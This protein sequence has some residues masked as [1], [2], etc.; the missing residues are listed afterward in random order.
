MR[1][2]ATALGAMILVIVTMSIGAQRREHADEV[3]VPGTDIM[4]KADWQLLLYGG[5][6]FAVPFA[7]QADADGAF[8][9]AP[10]GTTMALQVLS[11]TNWSAHKADIRHAYGRN[12]IIHDDSNRRL[13]I[14]TRQAPRVEHYIAVASGAKV[15]VAMIE[16]H[17]AS[18]A[19][20]DDTLKRIADSIGLAPEG[21]LR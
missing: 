13:W 5:C 16:L 19:D 6:R 15:C 21:G 2:A 10:D 4:L 12:S 18:R 7:W 1:T 9:R 17:D 20:R 3:R 11:A 14:E 8:S